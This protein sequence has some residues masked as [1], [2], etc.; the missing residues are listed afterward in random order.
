M[1]PST[2][3]DPTAL[4]GGLFTGGLVALLVSLLMVLLAFY[5]AYRVIKAAV[6]DGVTDALQRNGVAHALTTGTPYVQG[7]PPVQ[8]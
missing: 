2:S 6:R 8:R 4:L 3:Y 7:Y 5:V 1:Y